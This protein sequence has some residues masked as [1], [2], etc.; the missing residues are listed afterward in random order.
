MQ[1]GT[2]ALFFATQAGHSR[3]AQTLLK[4]G[5]DV[6]AAANEGGTPLFVACQCGHLSTVELLIAHR[7]NIHARF[8]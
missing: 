1:T 2:T 7:A 6:N 8:D 5:A 3:C 4:C